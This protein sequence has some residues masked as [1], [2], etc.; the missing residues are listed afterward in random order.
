MQWLKELVYFGRDDGG[1]E[2]YL[3]PDA[4]TGL[5][6]NEPA[7]GMPSTYT[8]HL[9]G[10]LEGVRFC[11]ESISDEFREIVKALKAKRSQTHEPTLPTTN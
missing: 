9:D 7:E 4:V 5:I 8:L 11:E 3:N 10:R 6:V 2:V 1:E